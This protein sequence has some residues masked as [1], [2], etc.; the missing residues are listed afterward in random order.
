MIVNGVVEP[1]NW[2]TYL[3]CLS[4]TTVMPIETNV[5]LHQA[6]HLA[7]HKLIVRE[8]YLAAVLGEVLKAA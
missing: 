3:C 1:M 8:R 7:E 5:P 2:H 4:M 6:M